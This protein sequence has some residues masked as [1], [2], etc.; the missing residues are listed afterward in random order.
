[1]LQKIKKNNKTN[2]THLKLMPKYSSPHHGILAF[3]PGSINCQE[4]AEGR[5]KQ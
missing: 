1:M 3:I 5:I 2:S 4:L